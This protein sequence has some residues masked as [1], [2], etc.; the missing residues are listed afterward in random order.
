VVY[1]CSG[2]YTSTLPSL[3]KFTREEGRNYG[4]KLFG[5]LKAFAETRMIR[6]YAP[7]YLRRLHW[8]YSPHFPLS[9]SE[10]ESLRSQS[11]YSGAKKPGDS[12]SIDLDYGELR[13]EVARPHRKM[14]S[15]F[16][17]LL[18]ACGTLLFLLLR[19]LA[20]VYRAASQQCRVYQVTLTLKVFL[21]EDI[22]TK[23]GSARREYF[24]RQQQSQARLREA[25]KLR[26]LRINWQEGLRSALPNLIDAQLRTRVQ[27][28][29]EHEPHD[30]EQVRSLWVEAQ[31]QT[32]VKTP[33]DK[34]NLLLESAKP[35][36]TEEE[37]DAGRAE[38]SAIL[39]SSGFRAAR[40]FAITMHDEFKTRAREMA[41]LE[42]SDRIIAQP[43][44]RKS[45]HES[46]VKPYN[47]EAS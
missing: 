14:N 38:A 47:A 39:N 28:C 42:D 33:A 19:E 24:E 18:I 9:A 23:L 15:I 11:Y 32:G 40:A 35:Y 31:E 22:Q 41:E 36:C 4:P 34:L 30:L 5:T 1:F 44:C 7:E 6:V 29:L 46:Q 17:L 26:T 37:F 10:A 2:A 3:R 13:A 8:R 45:R 20:L 27:E 16:S 12:V 25:E 21:T 43:G